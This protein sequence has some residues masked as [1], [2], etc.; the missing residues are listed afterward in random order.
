M[1]RHRSD[2]LFDME[3]QARPGY[4]QLHVSGPFDSVDL[5]LTY[6]EEAATTC[7]RLGFSKLLVIEELGVP[8]D[9]LEYYEVGLRLPAI[10]RGIRVALVDRTPGEFELNRFGEDVAVNRGA[11]VRLF[12]REEEAVGWLL[13]AASPCANSLTDR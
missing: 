11:E 4:L 2:R 5:S 1:V 13:Q 10:L 9:I 3:Y 7:R 6:W 8:G 12:H